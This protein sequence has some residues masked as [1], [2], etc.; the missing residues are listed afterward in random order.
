MQLT[1]LGTELVC[2]AMEK[3]AN[4]EDL[5]FHK[6]ELSLGYMTRS[7]Q[8]SE[9]LQMQAKFIE[10]RGLIKTMLEKPAR[11]HKLPIVEF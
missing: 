6:Q 9:F 3:I 10:K 5:E 11:K 1:Y 8:F 4:G 2:K 7:S